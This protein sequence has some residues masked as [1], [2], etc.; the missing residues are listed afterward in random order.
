MSC[1]SNFLPICYIIYSIINASYP[2]K[3]N[4]YLWYFNLYCVILMLMDSK[5]LLRASAIGAA[6]LAYI[7]ILI[8]KFDILSINTVFF[9]LLG[10][11]IGILVAYKVRFN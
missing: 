8:F 4:Q 5:T 10:A 11:G 6:A 9:A 3:I 2:A 7:G 1:K